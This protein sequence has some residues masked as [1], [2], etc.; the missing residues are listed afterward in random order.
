MDYFEQYA[1]TLPQPLDSEVQKQLLIKYYETKDQS[2]RQTLLEHNLRLCLMVAREACYKYNCPT[3]VDQTFSICYEELEHSL[4][5]YNPYNP[6]QAKFSSY[7]IN[8]MKL[9]L[10]RAFAY[11]RQIQYQL[12][13][14]VTI[15]EDEEDSSLFQFIHDESESHI[16]EDSASDAFVEDIVSYID[17]LPSKKKQVIQMYL[18]IGYPSRYTQIEIAKEL[19]TSRQNVSFMIND[20]LDSLQKYI[21]KNYTISMPTFK[22]NSH[23]KGLSF[24]NIYLRDKY[25]FESYYGLNGKEP[26][27]IKQLQHEVGLKSTQIK[28]IAY[29]FKERMSDSKQDE[30]IRQRVDSVNSSKNIYEEIFNVYYGINGYKIQE[31][32]EI[33]SKYG[34]S[35]NT[36]SDILSRFATELID[37]DQFSQEQLEQIKQSRVSRKKQQTLDK[38]AQ[39]YFS[40]YAENGYTQKSRVQLANEFHVTL[41]AIDIWLKEYKKYLNSL[42]PSEREAEIAKHSKQL[43]RE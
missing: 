3:L 21:L 41:S 11:E 9:V 38:Y 27:S 43:E 19:Q 17:T 30:P 15:N 36:L 37:N 22:D 8:N 5:K 12:V 26:K 33:C 23:V 32:H 29:K 40:Y 1:K 24:K 13:D 20:L 4:N 25:I 31:R 28:I 16:A 2:A 10:T 39:A 18:G 7:A 6:E 14:T 34:I 35:N 42:S